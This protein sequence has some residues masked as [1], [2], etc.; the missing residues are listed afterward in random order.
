MIIFHTVV[1]ILLVI[2]VLMQ[3]AKGEGLA[4]AFGGGGG[5][6]ALSGAVFGGRGAA[7]FLSKATS[8]LAIVFFVNCG[9]LAFMSSHRTGGPAAR[10]AV[11]EQA[12]REMERQQAQESLLP[13]DADTSAFLPAESGT[14]SDV[15][16]P[17][18]PVSDS[19]Q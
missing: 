5:G 18:T 13:E 1:C 8:V 7:T 4:G 12:Q 17:Q 19:G 3:S 9:I 6:G 11:T 15:T 10:S 14:E 16:F 2:S